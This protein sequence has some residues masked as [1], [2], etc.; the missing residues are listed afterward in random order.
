MADAIK[1]SNKNSI[2]ELLRFLFSLWVLYFHGYVPYKNDYFS[3]GSLAVEFFFVLTGMFLVRSMKKYLSMP[4]KDGLKTF[5]Y[6]RFKTLSVP[7]LIGEIFV[8]YY[9][10]VFDFSYNFLF[11]FLWYIRDLFI[12]LTVFYLLRRF[13]KNDIL[14]YSLAAAAS[15][16]VFVLR[17]PGGAFRSVACIP[18]GMLVAL[19]RPLSVKLKGQANKNLSNL[20]A[21]IGFI[22]VGTLSLYIIILSQ[23]T[24][25]QEYLLVILGYPGLLYFANNIKFNSKLLNWLG[26]LSFPIYSFQCIIR[27]IDAY[28]ISDSTLHFILLSAFVLTFSLIMHLID[29]KKSKVII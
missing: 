12:A 14:F 22:I 8:L 18:L 27:V 16:A 29:K 1:R 7:F 4:V 26:S 10:F 11:G 9:S 3:G 23:K 17:W 24:S 15:A 28:G 6:H 2:T 19:I 21:L 20:I 25:L 5:I 13:I